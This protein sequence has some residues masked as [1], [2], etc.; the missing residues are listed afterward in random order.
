MEEAASA[1]DR[2]RRARPAEPDRRLADRGAHRSTRRRS[3]S[4]ATCRMP[5]RHGMTLGELAQLF[6]AE[7]KIGADLTVVA[8]RNWTRDHWFDETGL[9]WINPSPNMRNL[10]QATL[11]PGIGAIEASERLGRPRHR[12]AVRADR[13]AVDR[14]RRARAAALN[15]RRL[16]GVRFYPVRFTPTSSKFAKRSLPRRLHHR[17]RPR[18]DAAGALGLEMA[19]ALSR[20]YPDAIQDRPGR[21]AVR[22]R[23]ARRASWPA[24]IRRRSPPPGPATKRAG[25]CCGRSICCI[26][27]RLTGLGGSGKARGSGG[28]TAHACRPKPRASSLEPRA[29]SRTS[30]TA[31]RR[32][33]RPSPTRRARAAA[34]SGR[35][36]WRS[37]RFAS[38]RETV[39]SDHRHDGG[40]Q[41]DVRDEDDEVDDADA[42]LSR[43]RPRSDVVVV[44]EYEIRK[45]AEQVTAAI[46]AARCASRRPR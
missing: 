28:L 8:M 45:S 35:C 31:S 41:H 11:Y 37:N 32:R 42:A 5:I 46:I 6:N 25:G 10:M 34:S 43:E 22:P 7:R 44:D 16:P 39:I 38:A 4:S 20:L 18:S 30:D 26:R 15:A 19:S 24:K 13:R 3:A 36:A 12:H 27:R 40:R 14:R 9:P 1:E 33:P 2:G 21:P 29:S 17:H 23:R